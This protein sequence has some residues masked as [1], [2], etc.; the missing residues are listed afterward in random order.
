MKSSIIKFLPAAAVALAVGGCTTVPPFGGYDDE[1]MAADQ[2]EVVDQY[3]GG[4]SQYAAD[5][6]G[7]YGYTSPIAAS[8]GVYEEYE[9]EEA[10][11]ELLNTLTVYFGY[12]AA[13]VAGDFRNV[14]VAH[15]EYLAANPDVTVTVEGHCDERGSRE[16]NIALGERR[17][18]SVKDLLV[19]QGADERQ[20]VTISYGEERP[21]MEGSSEQ[22]WSKNRRAEF[23]Y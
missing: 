8:G 18:N 19:A 23:L 12:D 13:N 16:Y 10:I 1:P 17:A 5:A 21:A 14:V 9:S 3:Y 11:Q 6:T 4:D 7:A 20:I 22:A 2:V 15:G